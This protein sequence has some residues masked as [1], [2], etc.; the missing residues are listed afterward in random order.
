MPVPAFLKTSLWS[1]DLSKMDPQKGSG[2]IITQVLNYGG[3]KEIGW[4]RQTYSQ[5]R[6]KEVL[7]HPMR[8]SWYRERLRKWLTEFNLQIDPLEFELA[9]RDLNPRTSLVKEFFRRKGL[10]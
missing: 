7:A 8:G 10:I 1:Y 3:E 4:I 9:I 5:E 6:I 2:E